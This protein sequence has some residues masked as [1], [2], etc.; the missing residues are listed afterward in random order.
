MAIFL[1]DS[2]LNHE[3]ELLFQEARFELILISPFIKLHDRLKSILKTKQELHELKIVVVYGKNKSNKSKSLGKDDLEFFKTFPNIEIRYEERLHA[4]YYA[5]ENASILSSMNLYDYSQNNNIEFGVKT[6]VSSLIQSVSKANNLDY[7]AFEYFQGIY[8]NAQ[9]QFKNEPQY[10]S[11]VPSME[12]LGLGGISKKYD[13]FKTVVNEGSELKEDGDNSGVISDSKLQP[14]YCI[15]YGTPIPFDLKMPMSEKAFKSWS[16][17]ED[18]DYTEK[19]C[20][21]SGEESNGETS[22]ARPVLKKNWKQSRQ[23]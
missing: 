22:F 7:D 13:G 19:Y 1:K 2:E 9:L 5:N 12:K 16:R 8:N 14:G 4:K 11:R 15:R 23:K 17:Y 3:L 21:F 18:K 6:R 10:K 20:H